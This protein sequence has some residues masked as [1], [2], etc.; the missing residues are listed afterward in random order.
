MVKAIQLLLCEWS[1]FRDAI[2]GLERTQFPSL[3]LQSEDALNVM[4]ESFVHGYFLMP[5]FIMRFASARL[6]H[7]L[8]AFLRPLRD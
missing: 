5:S 3:Q 2:L 8:R 6:G 1:I 4:F 7:F